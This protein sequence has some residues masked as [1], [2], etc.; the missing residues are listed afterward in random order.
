MTGRLA[1]DVRFT[2]RDDGVIDIHLWGDWGPVEETLQDSVTT[3]APRGGDGVNP[4]TFWI[5]RV[6]AAIDRE[7]DGAIV[8]SGNMTD[9]VLEAD[10]LVAHSHYELFNDQRVGRAELVAL[11]RRWRVVVLDTLET[12]PRDL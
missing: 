9:L 5:D 1:V 7:P 3:R 11:L 6:L 10:V 2:H 4:S 12:R 8:A